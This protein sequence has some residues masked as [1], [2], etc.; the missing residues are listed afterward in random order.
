MFQWNFQ[1]SGALCVKGPSAS[2]VRHRLHLHESIW[3]YMISEVVPP[4]MRRFSAA[5]EAPVT[6]TWSPQ[7]CQIIPVV[8]TRSQAISFDLL[9]KI[10]FSKR[11]MGC[12]VLKKNQLRRLRRADDTESSSICWF[13]ALRTTI[14]Q[15]P[16]QSSR[17][18][19]PLNYV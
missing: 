13:A 1:W 10:L 12:N 3:T 8:G 11:F 2:S 14:M 17:S 6:P 7:R 4:M 9:S 16:K 5:W 15:P 19:L 18:L